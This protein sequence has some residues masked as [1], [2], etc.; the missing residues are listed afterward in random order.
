MITNNY[1]ALISQTIVSSS[2][3]YGNN[4]VVDVN[5]EVRYLCGSIGFPNSISGSVTLN[6]ISAG[7]SIGTGDTPAT[8][9]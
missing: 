2:V 1:E 9:K 5:N 8:K 3:I 6:A 4:R 7:I